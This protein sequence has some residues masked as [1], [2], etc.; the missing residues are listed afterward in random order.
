MYV[1]NT[2]N[3]PPRFT[4]QVYT[5][6]VNEDASGNTLVTAVRAIDPD[7]DRVVY[8]TPQTEN[9]PFTLDSDTGE[10]RVKAGVTLDKDKYEVSQRSWPKNNAPR[11]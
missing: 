3:E 6:N 7:A 1:R 10:I 11:F 4:Q 5:P 2:K 8:S 9:V